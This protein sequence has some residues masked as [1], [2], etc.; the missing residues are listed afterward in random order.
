MTPPPC[1]LSISTYNRPGALE[2]CLLSVYQQT[3]KPAE[4]I[5][6]DDGSG[7]ETRELIGKHIKISPVPIRHIWHEDEGFRL[8]RIRNKAF[9]AAAS[10][11]I[12]QIDGDLILHPKFIED[13]LHFCQANTFISGTCSYL[14][15]DPT[16]EILARDGL[17]KLPIS[18]R[19]MDKRHNSVR[20]KFLSELLFRLPGSNK[21]I[22]Y[23]AGGNMAFWKKDLVKVNGHNEAFSSWGKE[24]N[25]LAVRLCNAGVKL[26]FIKFAAIAY[27]LEHKNVSVDQLP[28]N[29][30]LLAEARRTRLVRAEKGMDGN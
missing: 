30:N 22:H 20:R 4:I 10:E 8:A 1:S 14:H 16:N 7:V 11:Y 17:P 12:I 9:V 19:R 5:I 2:K 23:V 27:H 28:T 21:D 25:E 29:E 15:W 6:A 13:H 18:D 3:V 26:R 24:D